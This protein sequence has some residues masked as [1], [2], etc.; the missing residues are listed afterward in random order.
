MGLACF[1][2]GVWHKEPFWSLRGLEPTRPQPI[3]FRGAELNE[4]K[5]RSRD[6]GF[7]PAP[8]SLDKEEESE[9]SGALDLEGDIQ[10]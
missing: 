1:N 10:L 7:D 6:L 9:C 5:A 2:V 4:D 3:F 8:K